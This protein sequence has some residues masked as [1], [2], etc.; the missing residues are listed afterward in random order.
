MAGLIVNENISGEALEWTL[1]TFPQLREVGETAE[2]RGGFKFSSGSLKYRR[3]S[4]DIARFGR[5]VGVNLLRPKSEALAQVLHPLPPGEHLAISDKWAYRNSKH[6]PSVAIRE[7]RKYANNFRNFAS[8][9][10]MEGCRFLFFTMPVVSCRLQITEL[11]A[12]IDKSFEKEKLFEAAL[13]EKFGCGVAVAGLRLELPYDANTRTFHPH[14]H[15]IAVCDNDLSCEDFRTTLKE[16]I[17]SLGLNSCGCDVKDVKRGDV[18]KVASYVFK[19][20]LAAYA[21]A[22]ASHAEEFQIFVGDLRKRL[23]RTK[24]GFA[25]FAREQKAASKSDRRTG[26]QAANEAEAMKS[27]KRGFG[28]VVSDSCYELVVPV[29]ARSP[30]NVLCGVSQCIA[31]PS[32]L[33]AVWSTVQ[34]FSPSV[35]GMPNRFGETST[36]DLLNAAAL[37]CWENN[38]GKEYCLKEF[39]RPFA[40]DVLN[41]L[42]EDNVQYCTISCSSGVLKVLREIRDESLTSTNGSLSRPPG[43]TFRPAIRKVVSRLKSHIRKAIKR[44][45]SLLYK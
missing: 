14:F 27:K 31:L 21:M 23:V 43:R 18:E 1:K 40:Q 25:R 44:T 24:G 37:Q 6:L 30:Q 39:L 8:S 4:F 26:A 11:A 33:K 12:E 29:S 35:T 15:G 41:L 34:N 7:A 10:H 13:V 16:F 20:C 36:V 28:K 45:K 2:Y 3:M 42:E 22:Q 19:P 32:G 17:V 38:T 9:Q 5:L